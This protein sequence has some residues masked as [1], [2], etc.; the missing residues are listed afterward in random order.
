MYPWIAIFTPHIILIWIYLL[1]KWIN[2]S[3]IKLIGKRTKI[4]LARIR[5]WNLLIRS[6]TRYPLRHKSICWGSLSAQESA[7]HWAWRTLKYHHGLWPDACMFDGHI[8]SIHERVHARGGS[9]TD[10]LTRQV[11]RGR[12]TGS[13]TASL[14]LVKVPSRRYTSTIASDVFVYSVLPNREFTLCFKHYR[15]VNRLRL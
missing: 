7:S 11:P 2:Y 12:F 8:W 15:V 9:Y 6:Q 10:T 14:W 3:C 13:T 1:N 5:T 4:E